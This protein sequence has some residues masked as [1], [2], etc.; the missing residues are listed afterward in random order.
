MRV[1]GYECQPPDKLMT[2]NIQFSWH[3][4]NKYVNRKQLKCEYNKF[5]IFVKVSNIPCKFRICK[6]FHF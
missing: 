6:P 5:R 4:N 3:Q 2:I 1:E